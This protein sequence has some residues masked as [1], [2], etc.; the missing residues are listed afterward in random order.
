MKF[1]ITLINIGRN[2]HNSEIVKEFDDLYSAQEFA[3]HKANGFLFSSNTSL[4]ATKEKNIILFGQVSGMLE[5]LKLRRFL[6]K[7]AIIRLI[8][9]ERKNA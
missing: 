4:D 7:M 9:E 3:Y 8:Q 2:K 5:M 6:N 1:K